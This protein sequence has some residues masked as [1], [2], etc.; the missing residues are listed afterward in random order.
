MSAVLYRQYRPQ[1]FNEIVGQKHIKL[2]LENEI[3]SGR[4]AHAYLFA[5]M[6]GVGKTTTARVLAKSLNCL[7]RKK[8]EA[9]PCNECANCSAINQGNF[10]DLIEIDA[11]SNRGINEIR[12]LRDQVRFSPSHGKYKVFII[13]EVHMLTT[14]AFN[15]LL[16]TL[17][18]PP[19]YAIFILATTEIHKI[20][21]TI[22]S[23]CQRFDFK[24]VET[25]DII[26]ML[27]TIAQAEKV[28]TDQEVLENISYHSEGSVRDAIGLLQKVFSL[29]EKEIGMAQLDLVLPRSDFKLVIQMM[30]HLVKKESQAAIELINHM[31]EEGVDLKTFITDMIEVL[32]KMMLIQINDN[33]KEFGI[34]L[35]KEKEEQLKE[36]G[37]QIQK[38]DLIKI[39]DLTLDTYNKIDYSLIPQLNLELLVLK[40][41][42]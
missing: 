4:L 31:V 42:E 3:K 15:A 13:D 10:L 40:T 32:R 23:R 8:N 17:E 22:I 26:K 34:G 29:G 24:R 21:E 33:L 14:E 20:P 11:A 41:G 9:N 5:G 18:E 12:E 36:L 27:Q 28:K 7:N 39:L 37:Q 19:A 16:K 35:D 30:E 2:T 1:N 38:E 25:E 6:R